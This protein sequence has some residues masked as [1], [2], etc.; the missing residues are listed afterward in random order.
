MIAG[1]QTVSTQIA[2]YRPVVD[3]QKI[4]PVKFEA[5]LAEC[6]RLALQKH[7]T[8][9]AQE[10]NNARGNFFTEVL[11]GAAIGSA[12]GDGGGY[13]GEWTRMGAAA[14]A[15]RGLN[16]YDSDRANNEPKR[17]VDRCMLGRGHQI[18]NTIGRS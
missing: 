10:F 6:Q 18:L 11:V 8:A 17:I 9:K 1:C 13:Q 14:G 12:I 2:T 5:D 4:D 7:E 16:S 15:A 3:T